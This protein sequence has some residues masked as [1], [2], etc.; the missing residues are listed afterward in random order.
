MN[1][2]SP[3]SASRRLRLCRI[4]R[5]RRA[6]AS[7]TSRFLAERAARRQLAHQLLGDDVDGAERACR[8]DA[9]PPPPDRRAPTSPARARA[10]AGW[11]RARSPDAASPRPCSRRRPPSARSSS[12]AR[13]TP[14]TGRGGEVQAPPRH[15]SSVGNSAS[16]PM[17]ARV[18]PVSPMVHG[19]LSVVATMASGSSSS[20]AN[21]FCSRRS[22]RAGRPAGRCRRRRASEALRSL[23]R[24][25]ALKPSCSA[26]LTDA[27]R[28]TAGSSASSG[29]SMSSESS[30][31]RQRE[32]LAADRDPAGDAPAYAAG[33]GLPRGG[34]T[35]R[36]RSSRDAR[37]APKAEARPPGG[38][39]LERQQAVDSPARSATAAIYHALSSVATGRHGQRLR[40]SARWFPWCWPP[41]R[42]RPG[43]PRRPSYGPRR[44][45]RPR[46]R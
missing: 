3:L 41:P 42:D 20:T 40:R 7:S 36:A 17:Q 43:T 28:A 19:R 10:P 29:S 5:Q 45:R 25:V 34:R 18:R 39:P 26:M 32:E 35:P 46:R 31:S 12:R 6:C 22:A 4:S 24:V 8:A 13:P 16:S 33:P 14:R 23:S 38:I 11:R 44:R 15:G 1:G 30:T 27:L 37:R 21:G 2:S 9:P